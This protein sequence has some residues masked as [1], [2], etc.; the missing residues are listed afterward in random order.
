MVRDFPG[1]AVVKTLRFQCRGRGLHPV[2][3]TEIPYA[4]Q[5]EVIIIIVFKLKKKKKKISFNKKN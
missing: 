5:P 1:G 3:G 2:Q 4:T